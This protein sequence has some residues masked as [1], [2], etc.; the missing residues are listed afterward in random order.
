MLER[1]SSSFASACVAWITRWYRPEK[2]GLREQF[3]WGASRARPDTLRS[4]AAARR[5]DMQRE[6]IP[7]GITSDLLQPSSRDRP[8]A[9][10]RDAD[11][12][13]RTPLR[14]P[15][16]I[17]DPLKERLHGRV[18]KAREAA[19]RVGDGQQQEPDACIFGGQ[20]HG[21]RQG[22]GVLVRR[23]VGTVVDVVELGDARVSGGEH[24]L[25]ATAAGLPYGVG[26]QLLRQCVHRVA[27]GPEVVLGVGRFYPLHRT[28]N[29]RWKAWLWSLTKPGA[30]AF[31]GQPFAVRD[32]PDLR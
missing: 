31:P 8:D 22:V 21:F 29:P 24:L 18:P 26:R 20:R 27:P 23:S 17:I 30:S 14:P 1:R 11:L 4:H 13:Q 5:V 3:D 32:G 7:T 2:S 16:E 28:R 19:P 9:V 6:I 25:V 15:P 12:D 10:G